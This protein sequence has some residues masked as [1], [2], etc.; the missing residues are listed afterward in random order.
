MFKKYF[1]FKRKPRPVS[2]HLCSSVLRWPGCGVLLAGRGLF[3]LAV[4][5]VVDALGV[6]PPERDQFL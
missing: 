2:S 4:L 5:E 3:A 1:M 6:L